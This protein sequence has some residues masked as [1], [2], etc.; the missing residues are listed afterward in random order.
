MLLDY[1]GIIPDRLWVGS[2]IRPGDVRELKSLGINTIINLQSDEDVAAYGISLSGIIAACRME[3]VEYRRIPTPDFDKV[4]FAIKLPLCV[5]ELEAA[6]ARDQSRVYLHCS[7]GI[8]R[9]PTTAAAYL[10]R[11]RGFSAAE[12][13]RYMVERRDCQPYLELLETYEQNLKSTA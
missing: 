11:A 3:D 13:C 10:I 6:L 7:A 12:A 4:A 5:A 9:S 2:F 1:D 8:N